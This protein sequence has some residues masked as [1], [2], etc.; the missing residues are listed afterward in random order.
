MAPV[1][2]A[3][4]AAAAPSIIGGAALSAIAMNFAIGVALGFV[5]QAMQKKPKAA[6]FSVAPVDQSRT[7]TIRQPISRRRVVYG[8]TRVSGPL[9]FYEAT[10]GD[11]YHHI[12]VP[13]SEGPIGGF[14]T[15]WADDT[16]ISMSQIDA[17]GNVTAG[18]F[19][20]KLRIKLH[21]GETSQTA[22]SDLVSETSV[23]SNFRGRG[24]AY[25]YA[26][27]DW[28]QDTF[29]NGLPDIGATVRGKKVYDTRT[30][31]T[32]Y[33]PNVAMCLR[34][35][36]TSSLYG[37]KM[38]AA[39]I[40]DTVCQA[41][42]NTCDEMVTTN[43][44]SITV[45]EVDATNDELVYTEVDGKKLQTGDRFDLTTTDTLPDPLA[46]STNYFAVL[47]GEANEGRRVKVAT[48]YA[49]ALAGTTVD[50]T[51]AGTGTHTIRKNAEP[52]YTAC[53]LVETDK[54]P[55]RILDDLRT[56]MAGR[57]VY[58]GGL[59]SLL[60]GA[61][62]T[63][64]MTLTQDDIISDI[65]IETRVSRRDRYNAVKGVY[66]SPVNDWQPSDFPPVTSS[67][68]ETADGTQ[69]FHELDLPFTSRPQTAQRIAKIELERSRREIS[70]SFQTNLR[71]L[72]LICGD[73]VML[74][75]DRFGWDEKVFEVVDWG[76][77]V[78]QS[79]GGP[80]LVVELTL[81][82]TDSSVYTFAA[83]TDESALNAAPRTTLP[84]PF[85]VTAIPELT[86]TT[87]EVLTQAGDAMGYI[88]ASWD[89][90]SQ[91]LVV[92]KGRIEA[93]FKRSV[94]DV[95]SETWSVEGGKTET[96]VG[97]LEN[98][99][100]YDLRVRAV[101]SLGVRSAWTTVSGFTLGSPGSGA[102]SAINY[103]LFSQT[104]NNSLDY[105]AFSGDPVSISLDYGAFS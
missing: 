46:T 26:R 81:R 6:D 19:S 28:D 16:P 52:R 37:L 31:S 17:N 73:T 24:I 15:I 105:G 5:S 41:S 95:W 30:A 45:T 13:I 89:A 68:Y 91:Y 84:D 49:N 67:T 32:V 14:V 21:T 40:D 27:V 103:G 10:N 38:E 57:A 50:L 58:A 9:T 99:V 80:A 51:D 66:I 4:L 97:P 42:A 76:L 11:R 78:Q 83:G 35:Y 86:L 94:D 79:G 74:T 20:G 22:D 18:K 85:N 82:E 72:S 43:T 36:L 63:P 96:R 90:L 71:A 64:A 8:E 12:I 29:P 34:D 7:S 59:W 100:N 1:I 60:A 92:N 3:G 69:I 44:V 98:L 93:Q 61:Y 54:A 70:V 102:S 2:I 55:V 33:T 48:S 87:E 39:E 104:V 25:I 47:S 77:A 75:L 101:N 62:P 53:G 88:V 56:A 65:T 23:D